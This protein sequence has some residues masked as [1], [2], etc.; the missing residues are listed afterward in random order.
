MPALHIQTDARVSWGFGA[1][2]QGL[3][4]TFGTYQPG[5]RA[6]RDSLL[7]GR[8]SASCVPLHASRLD[9]H[10]PPFLLRVP[11]ATRN[12]TLGRPSFKGRAET[13]TS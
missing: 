7:L 4:I 13:R 5:L 9:G 3:S 6:L 10:R 12:G 1:T 8:H 11:N 2:P